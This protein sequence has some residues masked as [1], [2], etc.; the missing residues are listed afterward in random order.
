MNIKAIL[1]S[2]RPWKIPYFFFEGLNM[3]RF[4][5][6]LN[7]P[8]FITQKNR[9]SKCIKSLEYSF[10]SNFF[11]I[12]GSEYFWVPYSGLYSTKDCSLGNSHKAI[13]LTILVIVPLL[14]PSITQCWQHRGGFIST[15]LGLMT[16]PPQEADTPFAV[17]RPLNFFYYFPHLLCSRGGGGLTQNCGIIHTFFLKKK[18]Y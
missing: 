13:P 11:H 16:P 18:P 6:K 14:Q 15:P 4:Q 8:H 5:K 1:D 3:R 9:L 2:F 12:G 7:F 10:K 17:F